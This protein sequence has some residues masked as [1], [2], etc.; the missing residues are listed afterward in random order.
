[1]RQP[2]IDPEG[3]DADDLLL[4]VTHR[5]GDVH[6][7]DDDGVRDGLGLGLPRAIALVVGDRN[8]DRLVRRVRAHRDLTLERLAIRAAEVTERLGADATDAGV[9]ILRVDDLALAL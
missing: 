4:L 2:R 6:H 5:A 9:A 7:V 3:L 8:D 1:L